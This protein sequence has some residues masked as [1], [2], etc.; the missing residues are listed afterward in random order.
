APAP[1]QVVG[2]AGAHHAGAD[3]DDLRRAPAHVE[4]LGLAFD[5][6][7]ASIGVHGTGG[8]RRCQSVAAWKARP[9]SIR[10]SSPNGRPT[11][12]TARGRRVV[13]NPHGSESAGSPTRFPAG[14]SATPPPPGTPRRALRTAPGPRV[15]QRGSRG[16]SIRPAGA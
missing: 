5:P 2:D 13:L 8:V 12:C 9:R 4:R 10:V 3:D 1:R 16:S 6:R 11:S 15:R 14:T 7:F